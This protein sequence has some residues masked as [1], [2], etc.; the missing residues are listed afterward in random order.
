MTISGIGHSMSMQS[1]FGMKPPSASNIASHIMDKLDTDGDGALSTDE[2]SKDGKRAKKILEADTNGDGKVTMDE[3]LAYISKKTAGMNGMH[4]PSASDIASHIMDK[5]D[6]NGDG[7][8]STDEINAGGKRSQNI[9]EADTNG[10][11]KVTMD[12]LLADISKKIASISNFLT[13]QSE[14]T[15][16]NS[17]VNVLA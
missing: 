2:I 11:G 1:M 9:L 6:T 8:L 14:Q 4:P 7:V 5:L 17:N 15:D 3:L 12:E 10:D 13:V 16:K